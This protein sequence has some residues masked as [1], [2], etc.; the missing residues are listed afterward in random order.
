[1]LEGA[2]A[3]GVLWQ[4]APGRFLLEIP[5]LAR[6]LV[7]SGQAI[8][9]QPLA[10]GADA[11]AAEIIRFLQMTPLAALLYQRGLLA[12]HAAALLPS[13]ARDKP[14][15]DSGAILLAGDS[16]A[17]KSTLLMA[18][19]QRGWIP[20]ADDL[21]AI[22]LEGSLPTLFPTLRDV[23]LWST[24]IEQLGLGDHLPAWIRQMP[25]SL[26]E[27]QVDHSPQDADAKILQP[28]PP[29][30]PITAI[31][32][33]RVYN[34]DETSIETSTGADRFAAL[35]KLTYNTHIADALVD[36]RAYFRLASAISKGVPVYKLSRPRDRSTVDQ[37]ADLVVAHS[38]PSL[39]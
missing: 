12:L 21:A 2:V 15:H 9:I 25:A 28:N 37:L 17:G 36:H 34:R 5:T 20:L 6:Y 3:R 1:M 4:A 32:W 30:C 38:N 19:Y 35:G 11:S 29:S 31:F 13:D 16:G 10:Q 27:E 24:A 23:R 8:T 22:G 39:H 18:L 14:Q 7:E 26:A 33:L